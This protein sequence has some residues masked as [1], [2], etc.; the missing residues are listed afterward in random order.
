P[1]AFAYLAI[2]LFVCGNVCAEA[3]APAVQ[4]PSENQAEANGIRTLTSKYLILCTDVP[5]SP[6][7]DQLPAV[8]DQAVPKWAEYFGVDKEKAAHWQAR[9]YLIGDRRRFEAL[10]LLPPGREGFV[11]GISM[12]AELWLHDQPTPYYRRHLLLHE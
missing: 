11:N 9:A 12:G 3:P 6:E 2:G 1:Q 8:F 4:P 5:S 10:H 7:I